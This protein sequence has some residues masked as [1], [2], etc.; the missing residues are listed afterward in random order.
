MLW[1]SFS[2]IFLNKQPSNVK[3][4]FLNEKYIKMSAKSWL[5]TGLIYCWRKVCFNKLL[6]I[7]FPLRDFLCHHPF[8]F[9]LMEIQDISLVGTLRNMYDHGQFIHRPKPDPIDFH[10]FMMN[11]PKPLNYI[12]YQIESSLGNLYCE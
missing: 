5:H 7:S 1:K 11:L 10:S 9:I 6:F 3:H 4:M 8:L 12:N 2:Y